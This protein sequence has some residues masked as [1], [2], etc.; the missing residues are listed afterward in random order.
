MGAFGGLEGKIPMYSTGFVDLRALRFATK[1]DTC[2]HHYF[3]LQINSRYV[4]VFGSLKGYIS[5][6]PRI[7]GYLAVLVGDLVRYLSPSLL[8]NV[9]YYIMVMGVGRQRKF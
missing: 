9:T 3:T 2:R 6:F 1:C 8:F 7:S 4:E 5:K